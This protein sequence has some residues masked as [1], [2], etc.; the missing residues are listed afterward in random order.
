ME[1]P[2]VILQQ[3]KERVAS[4]GASPV[5]KELKS[6]LPTTSAKYNTLLQIE[7]EL[8]EVK[9]QGLED[10]LSPEELSRAN[11]RIRRSLLDFIDGLEAADFDANAAPIAAAGGRKRGHVLY[12][13]PHTM[14][15]FT[16]T[17]CI[18]RIA[19]LKE[20][21]LEDLDLDA[22]V[23][24][25]SEVVVSDFMRVEL[26]DPNDPAI[27]RI[28][29][30]SEA[31]QF[32]GEDDY[33]EWLFYVK[34]M[35]SGEHV[36]QLKIIVMAK[37]N[38]EYFRREKVLEESV[39]IVA[40]PVKEEELTFRQTES[41]EL[42]GAKPKSSVLPPFVVP[43]PN[44]VINRDD[45]W[46]YPPSP[47]P[48]TP[49]EVGDIVKEQQAEAGGDPP[50]QDIPVERPRRINNQYMMPLLA[51][52]VFCGVL[53]GATPN[54][55]RDWTVAR[56]LRDTPEGYQH[57]IDN[58][59]KSKHCGEAAFRKAQLTKSLDDYKAYLKDYPKGKN[60]A[61]ATWQ[62]A[63]I[64]NAPQDFQ[65]Y[66]NKYPNGVNA[67]KAREKLMLLETEHWQKVQATRDTAK[68][69]QFLRDF[70]QSSHRE[71][72]TS[73]LKELSM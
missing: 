58:H 64:T 1:K 43:T 30:T 65:H 33:T 46:I 3:L 29:S 31:N 73:K 51:V 67:G 22:E 20:M 50:V 17:K 34:P 37:I 13:V 41:F 14:E 35:Q 21:L 59:R 47:M 7:A 39:V 42:E 54:A 72:V 4:D 36:L 44:K 60:G 6:L 55:S 23:R 52:V 57:F 9:R 8:K 45:E 27:F 18:V 2:E 19:L 49:A 12:R 25:R 11:N 38:D 40:E 5:I 69:Q 24:I 26:I 48:P 56:Y 68:L 70:P 53:W 16:E 71:A 61:K 32:I 62:M 15:L 10:L 63:L 28:R 66:L